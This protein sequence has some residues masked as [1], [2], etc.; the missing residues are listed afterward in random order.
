MCTN[1]AAVNPFI[2]TCFLSK[3]GLKADIE[4]EIDATDSWDFGET[5]YTMNVGDTFFGHLWVG[6]IDVFSVTLT[7]GER[8]TVSLGASTIE[9]N[10]V[11]DTV[12]LLVNETGTILDLSDDIDTSNGNHYS[13]LEFSVPSTGEYKLVA[14]TFNSYYGINDLPDYGYYQMSIEAAPTIRNFTLD[15]IA[16][17][18]TYSGWGNV[19]YKWDVS[20]GDTIRVDISGLTT[21]GQTLALTALEAWTNVTGINFST[22]GSAQITFTDHNSGAS[23]NFSIVSNY[24]TSATVNVSES[25][26]NNYG[27]GLNGYAFQ[28]YIHEVGHALG[29]AHGGNYDGNAT[30]GVDNHYLNDSWQTSVMSYFDQTENTSVNA[31]KAYVFTPQLADIIAVQDLYGV[32]GNIRTDNTSYGNNSTA[33]GYYDEMGNLTNI[34]FT[35]LDDGGTDVL[36][37]RSYSGAQTV[38]LTEEAFSSVFGESNNLAIARG[39]VIENVVTGS[40]GDLIYGN[41]V[42]N[43]IT[44]LAG[45]DMIYAGDGD[46]TVFGGN[47]D[48]RLVGE[49]GDD[50]LH[51]GD[52]N[53]ILKGRDGNNTLNGDAGD[54]NLRGS[55]TGDDILNGGDGADILAGLSGADVLNGGAGNDFLYGGRNDDIV[56]GGAGDD[57]VRGN[58][59]NDLL[60][61]DNGSDRLFGGGGNDTLDGGAAKDYLLGEAGNDSLDGGTG[62]DNLTGGTGAD[63][64]VFGSTSY[65]YDRVLDFEIGVDSIDLTDHGFT[66]FSDVTDRATDISAGVKIAFGDGNVLLLEGLLENQLLESDFLF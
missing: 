59:N 41:A 20:P 28:T 36:D 58:L 64:F 48:D 57:T 10:D 35:I 50:T 16:N 12:L 13:A 4:E 32:A 7:E 54:D 17:Q 38:R 40:G 6:D 26:L 45:D 52:G 56:I 24:M 66:Q 46:D 18:L 47:G 15:E 29:L 37:V 43:R 11:S 65:G 21:D 39:T 9:A 2:K 44:A 33:G 8:Y 42:A 14:S 62:D 19:T 30:Y 22:T 63:V 61:G 34:T 60:S 31:S 51:G 1:C 49:G 55:D 53:D 27:V 25:W 23:A 3:T 5:N